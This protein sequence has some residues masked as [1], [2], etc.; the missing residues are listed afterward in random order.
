MYHIFEVTA[1]MSQR[2]RSLT[3]KPCPA[4]GTIGQLTRVNNQ[5]VCQQCGYTSSN[6]MAVSPF[7]APITSLGDEEVDQPQASPAAR[8]QTTSELKKIK[9]RPQPVMNQPP[10][11]RSVAPPVKQTPA[12]QKPTFKLPDPSSLYSP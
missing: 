5:L 9:P 8:Q 4:C 6:P 12:P 10:S 2:I 3:P 11:Q 7:T 1:F